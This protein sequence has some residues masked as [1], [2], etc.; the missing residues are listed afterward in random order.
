MH[1][2]VSELAVLVLDH[3]MVRKAKKHFQCPQTLAEGNET[4]CLLHWKLEWGSKPATLEM[5]VTDVRIMRAHT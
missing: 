3:M 5:V 1:R 2:L 4:N